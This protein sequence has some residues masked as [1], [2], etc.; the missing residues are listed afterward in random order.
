M[1]MSLSKLWEGVIDQETWHAA[2]HGVAKSQTRLRDWTDEE[3][4]VM[5][6][7]FSVLFFF[8]FTF[9]GQEHMQKKYQLNITTNFKVRRAKS[10]W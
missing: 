2:V 8:H 10:K 1:V 5:A 3:T 9:Q 4:I 6:V 7:G